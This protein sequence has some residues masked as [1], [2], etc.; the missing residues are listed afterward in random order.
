MWL[1][2]EGKGLNPLS[3]I[4]VFFASIWNDWL[5]MLLL[6]LHSKLC[7]TG[8]VRGWYYIN[9]RYLHCL[10]LIKS[11]ITVCINE[12]RTAF[13][14]V[15]YIYLEINCQFLAR[16]V[17]SCSHTWHYLLTCSQLWDYRPQ[18]ALHTL[19]TGAEESLLDFFP[20]DDAGRDGTLY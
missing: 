13:I 19:C 17:R 6:F 11:F 10:H 7:F 9:L 3:P 15:F 16:P 2:S 1:N 12:Y 5:L 18:D 4:S 14:S 8:I 20:K